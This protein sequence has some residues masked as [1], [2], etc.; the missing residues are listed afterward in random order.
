MPEESIQSIVESI[1]S[2]YRGPGGAIAVIKDGEV[3]A[4]HVWGFAN[5]DERIPMTSTTI[6]PICSISKQMVCYAL[7]AMERDPATASFNIQDAVPELLPN[8]P[9]ADQRATIQDLKNMTSGLRDYWALTTL[10][11]A[12]PEGRFGV[13][14]HAPQM[15]K[16]L[17]TSHFEPGEEFSYCNV[18]WH[19]LGLLAEKQ[20]GQPLAEILKERVFKP[21]GMKTARLGPDTAQL[22]GSTKGYEGSDPSGYFP[23]V[24][25][26][27]WEGDAG[28]I[29]CLEDMIAYERHLHQSWS[30]PNS[31][32]RALAEEQKY[33]DG[34]PTRYG[35]GLVRSKLG[36]F[37]A[38]GHSGGLR[39]WRLS[40][41]H[42]PEKG[43]S[44]IVLFNHEALVEE[45]ASNILKRILDI[46][47]DKPK[48]IAPTP[49]WD[50]VFFDA[51]ARRAITVK[52]DKGKIILSNRVRIETVN[53]TAA[54]RA[55]SPDTI[56]IIK[57]DTLEIDQLSD[58]HKYRA[59]RLKGTLKSGQ[60][61]DYIGDF[62]CE[63]ID[64]TFHCTGDGKS[65]MLYGSF[66][67]FLGK[68]P[69]YTVRHAGDDVW[70]LS[71]P[72]SMDAP[73]PGDWTLA[74]KRDE[75]G[76]VKGVTIG[77]WLARKLEYVKK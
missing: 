6:L 8:L 61:A 46:P 23:A 24:N 69:E 18:N 17:K 52:A 30:D 41:R 63:E 68:G 37:R 31:I 7:V 53:L 75:K 2:L 22:P 72:R 40:R 67:G 20:A 5:L 56:A 13:D 9:D 38:F 73:A 48:D 51:D 71:N 25:K 16:L 27:V 35:N 19:I 77:C 34:T 70:L 62:Y 29:A 76:G 58:H 1:P 36:E 3:Q 49:E 50:G 12:H 60:A 55:E 64:S 21:A 33:P 54:E 11:G 65:G 32:Y 14:D 42:V 10:C 15:R 39:G 74:F 57:G 44:S 66:D 26:I 47:F 43:L 28:V 4:Q 59:E 45:A